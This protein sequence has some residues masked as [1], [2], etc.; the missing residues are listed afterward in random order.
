MLIGINLNHPVGQHPF[1]QTNP[2]CQAFGEGMSCP[3]TQAQAQI[4]QAT[5]NQPYHSQISQPLDI[6]NGLHMGNPCGKLERNFLPNE[7]QMEECKKLRGQAETTAQEV[8]YQPYPVIQFESSSSR[9][10]GLNYRTTNVGTCASDCYHEQQCHNSLGKQVIVGAKQVNE[11]AYPTYQQFST[12]SNEHQQYYQHPNIPYE[13]G[14]HNNS[15]MNSYSSQAASMGYYSTPDA[16]GDLDHCNIG[17]R[18]RS[19]QG[20]KNNGIDETQVNFNN[21]IRPT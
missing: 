16:R 21:F 3:S 20:F 8:E 11:C 9:N 4:S 14:H 15:Y 18:T 2:G 6:H 17:T 19:N 1:Q 10:D 7:R 5:I 12:F 13:F